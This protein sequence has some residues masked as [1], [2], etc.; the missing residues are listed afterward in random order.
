MQHGQDRQR[1]MRLLGRGLRLRCPRCGA[2][3]RF[4][5]WVM[6]PERCARCGLRFE[7]EQGYFIGA[8]YV[9]YA[10]TVGIVVSGYFLLERWAHLSLTQQLL[11]WGSVS[12]LF[13][14]LLFR[15]ARVLWLSFDYLFNPEP[16]PL[17]AEEPE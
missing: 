10:L 6:M 11:L 2:R 9:N 3:I 16:D 7:R 13:P 15:H 5:N 12:I 17:L 14:L 1:A 4:R 8:M